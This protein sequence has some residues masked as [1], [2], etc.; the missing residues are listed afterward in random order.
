VYSPFRLLNI[1]CLLWFPWIRENDENV[2]FIT[3]S[4]GWVT[5]ITEKGREPWSLTGLHSQNTQRLEPY[6]GH[7][8]EATVVHGSRMESSKLFAATEECSIWPGSASWCQWYAHC[9]M[10]V[11]SPAMVLRPWVTCYPW[12]LKQCFDGRER[13]SKNLGHKFHQNRITDLIFKFYPIK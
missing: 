13:M 2:P 1:W 6:L 4:K 5:F 9:L 3:S 12:R 11:A 7:S 8:R 10:M